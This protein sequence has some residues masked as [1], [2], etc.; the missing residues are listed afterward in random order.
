MSRKVADSIR[1]GLEEAL[2]FADGKAEEGRYG[3]HVPQVI[4]VR[5]IRTRL[6]MTPAGVRRTVRLQHQ[7]ATPLGAGKARAGGADAGY[8]VVID[9]APK[10]VQKALRVA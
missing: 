9:H 5:A 8:L 6:G 10:V 7:H 3:V 1:R 2:A 4:D